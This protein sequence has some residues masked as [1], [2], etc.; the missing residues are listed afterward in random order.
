[1]KYI[2]KT[3][4]ALF[5]IATISSCSNILEEVNPNGVSTDIF[6]SDLSETN[7]SLN[8]V[9]SAMLNTFI[10]NIS[11]ESLRADMGFPKT[12]NNPGGRGLLFYN[13]QF[14]NS[15]IEVEKKWQA[16]YQV[17]FRANQVI[18]GLENLQGTDAVS[19]SLEQETWRHQMA[20]ARFFRGLNHFYLHNSFNNGKIIIRD[21]IPETDADFNKALSS[22]SE[23]IAFY[24]DDLLY[25]YNNLPAQN[26]ADDQGRAT[27]GAAATILGTS[28]LYQEEYNDAMTYFND[29]INNSEYGY[30]LVQDMSLLF[31]N[32]GEFNAESILEINYTIDVLVEVTQWNEESLSTRLARSTAPNNLGGGGNEQFLP[33]AWITHAYANEPMDTLDSRNRVDDGM[34]GTRVRNVPL[35]AS[36]MIA[37]VQDEDTE[38]YQ[39]ASV[40]IACNFAN[41]G[42][43][44]YKK[45]SNHDIV[46]HE[47]FV[48]E[49]PWKSGKNMP[50]NR[51]AEVY[52]MLAECQIKTGD[53][54]G[55]LASMNAIRSRWALQLLGP[56]DGSGAMFDGI[57]YT[58]ATLMDHLMYVEKPL[59]L[60]AEGNGVRVN[61][62]RRWGIMKQRFDELAAMEFYVENYTYTKEDGSTANRNKCLVQAG[63]SPN[64]NTSP[65][66][67]EYTEASLY[68]IEDLHSYLPI[69]LS[70]VQ[71]NSSID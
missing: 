39:K 31:T 21:K 32:A 40:P 49:T 34:G 42:F 61:D 38:Y 51:L 62:L 64:P 16:C 48:G 11:P 66:I 2:F 36:A 13:Q 10:Y 71:N 58:A 37:L 1:M 18:Q 27:K 29:V 57:T 8:G 43:S 65:A 17:I 23:V 25:A 70:E 52:L 12:R 30:E 14:T 56:D 7:A 67:S 4:I 22:S 20:Q 45:Y 24:R 46:T 9:Y 59:E 41:L 35:R 15:T 50:L 47:K 5:A 19:D 6:W 69:P 3:F 44:F 26:T 60:S 33:T 53:I 55:A 68:F 54:T 63:P 28:H